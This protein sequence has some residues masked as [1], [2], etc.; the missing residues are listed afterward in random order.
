MMQIIA[1]IDVGSNAIRIAV[2]RLDQHGKVDVIDNVR[3][4]VRLGQDVFDSGVV[5][6]ETI[7]R[8]VEAFNQFSRIIRD[9]GVSRVRAVATSAMREAANRDILI[10]RIARS[11]K[12]DVEVISGEEE[13][14][15]I[16][17]AVANVVDLKG[18]LA[19]LIDIG[20]GSVEVTLADGD[21]ILITDS[22]NMG[23]VR[24]L[25]KLRQ[26][27]GNGL[28]FEQL[29]REYAE[30]ARGRIERE[31][32]SAK[33]D[34]CVGTGG[35]VEELGNLR[36][37]LFK[38]DSDKVITV[39]ELDAIIDRLKVLTPEERMHEFKLRPDR[40]DVILPAS[41][42]LRLIAR[43]GR[44]KE[45]RIP[46][47]GLK[48]GLLVDMA[49]DIGPGEHPLR[50]EQVWASA[51]QMGRKYQYDEQHAKLIARLA[52]RLFDETRAIHQLDDES[53]LLLEVATLLHDIG[54]FI[55]TVD[56]DKHGY[57]LLNANYLIGLNERQQAIV[58]NIVR[59][60]RKSLP[61]SDDPAVRPLPNKDRQTAIDL[62]ALLRLADSLDASHTGR[63]HD[64]R[65]KHKKNSIILK[66]IGD[67]DLMLE[68]WALTKRKGLFFETFGVK[69]DVED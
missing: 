41:I 22:Y 67:G 51:I 19:L 57:Y 49:Q 40:A 29:A 34:L 21:N 1:S 30:A 45:I 5:G 33:I 13:A 54:H 63:V 20:G 32:G 15:L 25:E 18:K 39:D 28:A 52:I 69:L 60:H 23:T 58:A 53:R 17:L 35:N 16:Y 55:H 2:G 42:A 59:Y 26:N 47:V 37:K 8:T 7:S 65:V 68:K 9:Y 10:D 44:V 3:L 27:G 14:R 62:I 6:E 12:I 31:I 4:P 56:H 61:G 24:M 46:N 43:Q 64:L 48:D 66:L 50:R 11:A 36:Q 38:R